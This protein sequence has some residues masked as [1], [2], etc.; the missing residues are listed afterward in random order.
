MFY[1]FFKARKADLGLKE[2]DG[3]KP[4]RKQHTPHTKEG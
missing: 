1:T 4:T 2:R 3:G